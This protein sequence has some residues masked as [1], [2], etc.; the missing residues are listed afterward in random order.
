MLDGFKTISLTV[1]LPYISI[2]ENGVTFNKTSI[3]KL[4]RPSHVLL[5][6]NEDKK[7]IAVQPC[8]AENEDATPFLRSEGK[9]VLSV[10]WNNKDL[11]NTLSKLMGWDLK[12]CGYRVDGDYLNNENAMVFDLNTATRI[13]EKD[14]T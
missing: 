10:R 1:G 12:E 5:M 8:D 11:L 3:V 13:G 6:I 4:G 14:Q 2:T 9:S 7:Q